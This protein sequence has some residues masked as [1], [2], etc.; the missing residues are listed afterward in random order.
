[1]EVPL[2]TKNKNHAHMVTHTRDWPCK[3]KEREKELVNPLK[4]M[5]GDILERNPMSVNNVVDDLF[6][7]KF[8]KTMKEISLDSILG[9]DLYGIRIWKGV[10]ICPCITDWSF[11]GGTSGEEPTFQCR[12]RKTHGFNHWVRKISWRRAWQPTPV[13]LPGQSH[14]QRRLVGVVHRVAQGL[15]TTEAI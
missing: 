11:P 8:Y 3:S 13:F 5:K 12:R 10:N 6:L 15:D 1:M 2:K 9:I 7:K 14:G 4:F